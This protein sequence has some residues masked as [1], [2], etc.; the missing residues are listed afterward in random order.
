MLHEYWEL[1]DNISRIWQKNEKQA[2]IPRR[3]NPIDIA[4]KQTGKINNTAKYQHPAGMSIMR[5]TH[6]TERNISRITSIV[7]LNAAKWQYGHLHSSCGA[8]GHL[9]PVSRSA[10]WCHLASSSCPRAPHRLGATP[11]HSTPSSAWEQSADGS[12]TA[13]VLWATGHS[14]HTLKMERE[15]MHWICI[16]P[17]YVQR[18]SNGM[19]KYALE[20]ALGHNMFNDGQTERE[21][22]HRNMHWATICSAM[23]K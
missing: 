11:W 18:W 7:S 12:P 19:R 22:M 20:Y 4:A 6:Q 1:L 9:E 16:G 15:N 14:R 13:A 3:A 2:S 23:V 17:P 21:N 10:S 8:A 5:R